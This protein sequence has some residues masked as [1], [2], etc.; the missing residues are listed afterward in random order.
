MVSL[1][2]DNNKANFSIELNERHYDLFYIYNNI[3]I[4]QDHVII[5]MITTL[6][7]EI[8]QETDLIKKYK[9]SKF[10]SKFKPPIT[11]QDYLLRLGKCFQCSQECFILA[12]IY[13]DRITEFSTYFIVNSL[14]V[15]RFLFLKIINF[16]II[17]Q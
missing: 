14:N 2:N 16:L 3:T 11:L 4:L 9:I 17:Q 5:K 15:H 1:L 10:N 6:L 7:I 13:I 12:L 8:L